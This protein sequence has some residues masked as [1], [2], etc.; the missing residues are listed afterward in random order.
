MNS[1]KRETRKRC[2]LDVW[3]QSGI[4]LVNRALSMVVLLVVTPDLGDMLLPLQGP[5]MSRTKANS[6]CSHDIMDFEDY[7]SPFSSDTTFFWP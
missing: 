6:P 5:I 2:S 1:F 7:L 4:K 3:D